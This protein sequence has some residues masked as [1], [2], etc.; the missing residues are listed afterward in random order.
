MRHDT[1]SYCLC[2]ASSVAFVNQLKD[3]KKVQANG[4]Q[5]LNYSS[6]SFIL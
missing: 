3:D 1:I 4:I 2:I 6:V 5:L